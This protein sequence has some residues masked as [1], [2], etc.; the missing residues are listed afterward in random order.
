M[1]NNKYKDKPHPEQVMIRVKS[2]KAS[3]VMK[4]PSFI[5]S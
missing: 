4:Y 5:Q 3:E 2:E 1:P